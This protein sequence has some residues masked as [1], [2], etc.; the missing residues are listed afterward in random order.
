MRVEHIIAIL[1][2]INLEMNYNNILK[3]LRY[4]FDYG[5]DKMM[6]IFSKGGLTVDRALL[7]NWLKNEDDDD[8]ME[9]EAMKLTI[10][11]N[12]FII[13]K[14]GARGDGPPKP[15]KYLT[16]N[17]IFKKLKIALELTTEDILEMFVLTGKVISMHEINSFLRNPEKR[18]FRPMKD[19]YLRQFTFGIQ[20]KFRPKE[21]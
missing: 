19:Q 13:E 20:D 1:W 8:Y 11:L 10:F 6:K 12:G 18:Q 15:E 17:L 7:S 2:F 14:R 4:T 21:E 3:R 16:N 5:D 9:M